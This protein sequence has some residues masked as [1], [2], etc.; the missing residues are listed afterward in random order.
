MREGVDT[1]LSGSERALQLDK[2][3]VLLEVKGEED[4]ISDFETLALEIRLSLVG[5]KATER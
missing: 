3:G 4:G 2:G 5:L 1:F